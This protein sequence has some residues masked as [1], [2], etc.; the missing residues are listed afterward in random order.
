MAFVITNVGTRES[1]ISMVP[2]FAL[3]KSAGIF[4]M[5]V[6]DPAKLTG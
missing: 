6:G 2:P 5:G 4:D 3:L 1:L